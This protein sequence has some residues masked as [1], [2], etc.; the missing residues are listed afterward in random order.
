MPV[1]RRTG[2]YGLQMQLLNECT[3]KEKKSKFLAFYYR[4]ADEQE[5]QSIVDELKKEHRKANHVCWAAV[6]DGQE[7]FKN[8]G[9]VGRPANTML[10]ILKAKKREQHMIAVVRYFGGVKLGSGGVKRAFKEAMMQ[11]LQ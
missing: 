3:Y 6:V 7:I 1:S 8:D 10:E 9:E 5:A 11:C 2:N 4:I